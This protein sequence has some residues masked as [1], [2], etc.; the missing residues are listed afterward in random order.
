MRDYD[1][2]TSLPVFTHAVIH[3]MQTCEGGEGLEVSGVGNWSL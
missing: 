3:K 1:L 2:G